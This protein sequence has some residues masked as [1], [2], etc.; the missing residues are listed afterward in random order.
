MTTVTLRIVASDRAAIQLLRHA[1][2]SASFYDL[3]RT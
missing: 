1:R 2:S 3:N